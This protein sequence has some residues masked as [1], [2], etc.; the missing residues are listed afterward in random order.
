MQWTLQD[1]E[2]FYIQHK[3]LFFYDRLCRFMA[4]GPF[5]AMILHHE[6]DAISQWRSLIGRTQPI[7]ARRAAPASLRA[8]YGITDTRNAFHGSDSPDSVRR[9]SRFFFP[10]LKL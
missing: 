10:D 7:H 1:A 9:E 4:S 8:L 5:Q 3:G 2:T 6:T